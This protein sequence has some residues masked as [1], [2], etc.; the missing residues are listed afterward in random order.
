[1]SYRFYAK[2]G[3]DVL[4]C[5]GDLSAEEMI[6]MKDR[7]SRL[8]SKQHRKVL[9]NLASARRVEFAGLGMLVERVMKVRAQRGDIRLCGMQP[10][11]VQTFER[12]GANRLMQ[13]YS[14]EEEAL[15][16]FATA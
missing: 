7:L 15:Q 2:K 11:V 5:D 3:V 9:L 6:R 1:M 4:C 13:N 14:T 8:M 16:S 10:E 12:V